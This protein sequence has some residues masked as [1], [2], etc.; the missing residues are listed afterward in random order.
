MPNLEVDES[1]RADIFIEIFKI[2]DEYLSNLTKRFPPAVLQKN[3]DEVSSLFHALLVSVSY[4][5]HPA[6]RQTGQPDA[7]AENPESENFYHGILHGSLL[8]AGFKVLSEVSGGEGR[9]D[10]TLYL[11]DYVCE[12]IVLKHPHVGKTACKD[13]VDGKDGRKL[14]ED[15]A[16]EKDLSAA[17]DA[18]E[19][20][21]RN[22]DYA[23]PHRA[24][25]YKVICLA[26]AVRGRTEVA[27]RF[28][29]P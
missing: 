23:G 4:R 6:G 27:A 2:I 19:A 11:R 12:G 14:A 18:A 15:A 5:Q 17:L 10:I 21:I 22:M 9:P 16:R 13:G 29:D 20:Q 7:P 24:A 1:S 26:V 3:S 8:S 28:V 25:G